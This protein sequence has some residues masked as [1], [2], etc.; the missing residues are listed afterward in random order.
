MG[1][2]KRTCVVAVIACAATALTACDGP[3]NSHAAVGMTVDKA[4]NPVIVLQDCRADISQLEL[5]DETRLQVVYETQ[6]PA[7]A[8]VHIPLL[9]GTDEWRPSGPVPK[10]RAGSKFV[11]KAWGEGHKY[12]GRGTEF[13]LADLKTLKPGQVRHDW[14]PFGQPPSYGASPTTPQY[15]ITSLDAFITDDCP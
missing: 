12:L 5:Y 13:T 4:G 1:P 11:V 7:Q 14:R 15:R 8:V 10:P 2:G 9:A 3:R 6:E